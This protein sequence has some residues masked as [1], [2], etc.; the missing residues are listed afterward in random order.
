MNGGDD[1]PSSCRIHNG[2]G[3]GGQVGVHA[4]LEVEGELGVR[5][6]VGIPMAGTARRP[7]DVELPINTV[8]PDLDAARLPGL[9]APSG[10]IDHVALFQGLLHLVVH[11]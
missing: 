2:R 10:D 4:P 7:R 8:E 11:G 3:S 5:P 6:H 9:P 1:G